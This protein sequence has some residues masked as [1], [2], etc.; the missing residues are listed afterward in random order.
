MTRGIWLA[1]AAV[2]VSAHVM[3]MSSGD[4][5]VEG[6]RGHYELRMPQYEVAHIKDPNRSIF[7]NIHFSSGGRAARQ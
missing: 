3:S 5:I 2:P 7:E 1:L 6:V 4:L